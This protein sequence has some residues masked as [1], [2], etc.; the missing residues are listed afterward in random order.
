MRRPCC[1]H[2]RT[3]VI[4]LLNNFGGHRLLLE[5]KVARF[6][7]K[8]PFISGVFPAKKLHS[9]LHKLI[10]GPNVQETLK[11]TFGFENRE[12]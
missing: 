7:G 12:W 5:D 6:S 9:M 4:E 3:C 10:R 1:A 2:A 8:Y 11:E